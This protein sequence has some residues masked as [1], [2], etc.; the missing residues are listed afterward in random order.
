[1]DRDALRAY[2]R[3]GEIVSSYG[4]GWDRVLEFFEEGDRWHVVVQAVDDDGVPI[5]G[6]RPREHST[7][8]SV[9][10]L[11]GQQEHR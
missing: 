8:P 1:M 9:E 3:P 11:I 6:H 4:G 5:P 10:V 7:W 2:F